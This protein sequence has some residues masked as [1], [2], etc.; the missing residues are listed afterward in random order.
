MLIEALGLTELDD[1]A[2]YESFAEHMARRWFESNWEISEAEVHGWVATFLA[3]DPPCATCG[4]TNGR[5]DCVCA[6]R[7][8]WT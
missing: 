7:V 2:L 3:T 4:Q 1:A 6:W 5:A 8:E